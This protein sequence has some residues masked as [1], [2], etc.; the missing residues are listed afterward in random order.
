[1]LCNDWKQTEI[2][3]R[4]INSLCLSHTHE[5][6]QACTHILTRDTHT[7]T[8]H[9]TGTPTTHT[10][11]EAPTH[12]LSHAPARQKSIQSTEDYVTVVEIDFS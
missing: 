2:F 7:H 12:T 6:E 11:T 8:P 5:Q 4:I 3:S 10:H 1:M 9:H